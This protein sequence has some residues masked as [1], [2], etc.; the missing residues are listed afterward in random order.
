MADRHQLIA[1]LQRHKPCHER[2]SSSRDR[3]VSFIETVDDCFFRTY[4][5]G[6]VTGSGMLVSADGQ[7]VLL[8]HH[9]F[10][11]IWICF[12]GHADGE[13]DILSVALRETQEETGIDDI[14]LLFDG[15]FDVDIHA[16]PEN[17]KK[18]EPAHEHFDIC[19]LL[20]AGHDNFVVSPES[21]DMK[22]CAYDE[23]IE[24]CRHD[25]RMI[26]ML[27]KWQAL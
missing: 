13:E 22:W 19:Y 20:Q 1:A 24:V 21:L 18:G 15:I 11:N 7:R 2:E 23:A 17:P 5:A 25:E 16:I 4:L 12:G 9:K 8:N 26:R 14:R 3:M 27:G 10:L 6:H